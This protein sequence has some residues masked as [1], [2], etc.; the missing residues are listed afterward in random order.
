MK[1]DVEKKGKRIEWK[2]EGGGFRRD[3]IEESKR[4]EKENKAKRD[5][6]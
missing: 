3:P 6:V 2:E 4:I 5:K 1:S